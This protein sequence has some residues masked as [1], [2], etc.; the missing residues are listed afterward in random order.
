[1]FELAWF[2]GGTLAAFLLTPWAVRAARYVG[3]VDPRPGDHLAQSRKRQ[4]EPVPVAGGVLLVA[5]LLG[6]SSLLGGTLGLLAGVSAFVSIALAGLVGMLDDG[7][8]GGLAPLPKVALQAG[9]ALPHALYLGVE[10]GP[11]AGL[12]FLL[13]AIVAQNAANTFD[14]QHG[15]CG[16]LGIFGLAGPFP[17]LAGTVAGFVPY[18]LQVD[19]E[20]GSRIYLGDAGSHL[21]GMAIAVNPAAWPVLALPLADL[22]RLAFVRL[23]AGSRPWRGD[24]R[25]LGHRLEDAGFNAYQRAGLVA[26]AVLPT[27]FVGPA[28]AL[29]IAAMA[30]S[31]LLMLAERRSG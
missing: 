21:I 16:V 13:F 5:L 11:A 6:V 7:L 23:Q 30:L 25:H 14:H 3:W 4:R 8:R 26:C 10:H 17:W 28:L 20:G 22:G 29:A 12:G 18:N 9:A 27:A 24:R 19:R 2:A 31:G 1:M 15:F